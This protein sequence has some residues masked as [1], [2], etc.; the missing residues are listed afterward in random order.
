MDLDKYFKKRRFNPCNHSGG[1]NGR[2][3]D[4]CLYE[5]RLYAKNA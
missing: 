2:G 4:A 1:L 5:Q 3:F